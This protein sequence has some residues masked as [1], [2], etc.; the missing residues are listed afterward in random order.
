MTINRSRLADTFMSLASIDSVSRHEARMADEI[1]G[2]LSPLAEEIFTDTAGQAVGSD[3]NNLVIKI[4]G[5]RD[6]PPLLLNAHMDT[7]EPGI[8]VRPRLKDG[9]FTS[10]GTTVLGADDKSAIAIIIET[11][12]MLKENN[13]PHGPLEIVITICEEIG[14]LGAKHLDFNLIS[15]TYGYALDTADTE[16]IVIRAPGANRFE[17]VVHGKAAHAGADPENGINAILLASQAVA[18]LPL[19]RI[20]AE[21]TCN[22]GTME[23]RG[24]TNIVPNRVRLS[25]EVR[26]HDAAKL[27]EITRRIKAAFETV[28]EN[29]RKE[30]ATGDLPRVEFHVENDFHRTAIPE[31]HPVVA[32]AETAAAR[33]GRPMRCRQSGGG[34]DA[35]VFFQNGLMV[36]VLG[37][38]MRDIHT[39]RESI[40]LADMEKTVAL[41]L[42]IISIHAR[43]GAD[44]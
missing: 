1:R 4:S 14:L 23:A 22:I 40:A 24:A 29:F 5:N 9:I 44:Q 37:T 31:D 35:N 21:T 6:V 12:R 16:G 43:G 11:V 18:G 2:I 19:G 20:D 25:G 26:S 30:N 3:S 42:E 39:V 28:V 10:D 17:V 38:G 36:G 7:V 33:L 8:G 32:L 27:A 15:A 13:L 41:L 34:S